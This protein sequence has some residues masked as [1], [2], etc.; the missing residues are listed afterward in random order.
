[1]N[2]FSWLALSFAL[3]TCID[4]AYAHLLAEVTEF[5][6]EQHSQFQKAAAQLNAEQYKLTLARYAD[7]LLDAPL[8][9][10]LKIDRAELA[11][12]LDTEFPYKVISPMPGP[13][14][15]KA[16]IQQLLAA[17]KGQM[18]GGTIDLNFPCGDGIY[19]LPFA[20]ESKYGTIELKLVG[21]GIP[22]NK[23]E[24]PFDISCLEI[25]LPP[26]AKETKVTW[27][28][29]QNT[30]CPVPRERAG[31]CLLGVA[32]KMSKAMGRLTITL[33]DKSEVKCPSNKKLAD[34]ARLKIYQEGQGWYHK[35]GYISSIDEAKYQAQ[36]NL[37]KKYKL[38]LFSKQLGAFEP[39]AEEAKIIRKAIAKL[40]KY[41]QA[42]EK[43][44][45]VANFMRWLWQTDCPTYL[46]LDAFLF[47][48]HREFELLKL[49]P[50]P[51]S[52]AKDLR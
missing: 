12:Y 14:K 28:G 36:L 48:R 22:R 10:G 27:L 16:E 44:A 42:K 52:L 38:A 21:I 15:M 50:A 30:A 24:R 31:E 7:L 32:E 46:K 45:T 5:I 13:K 41:P 1:M 18:R 34:F 37:F 17:F 35:H 8:F 9:L 23:D 2:A 20:F 40:D 25:E 29:T 49:Y 51:G 43:G 39:R 19:E 3:L 6:D 33:Q 26:D 4:V 47:E 11:Q